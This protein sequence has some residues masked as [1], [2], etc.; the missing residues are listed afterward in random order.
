MV[1]IGY[2]RYPGQVVRLSN[3]IIDPRHG[4][5]YETQSPA[6][7]LFKG[8]AQLKERK[9]T[10]AGLKFMRLIGNTRHTPFQPEVQRGELYIGIRSRVDKIDRLC[11]PIGL[12]HSPD[13]PADHILVIDQIT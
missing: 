13:S 11:I 9:S 5:Q 12:G 4:Y 10:V 2:L 6:A 7:A 8:K 3:I 1:K